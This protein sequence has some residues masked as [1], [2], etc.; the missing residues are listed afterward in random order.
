MQ[1]YDIK[2]FERVEVPN[3]RTSRAVGSEKCLDSIEIPLEERL[4][5]QAIKP[6]PYTF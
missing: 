2:W 6:P 3:K 1:K 4:R 5:L